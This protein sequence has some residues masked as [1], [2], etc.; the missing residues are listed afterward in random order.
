MN[1]RLIAL[2]LALHAAAALW[3]SFAPLDLPSA[4]A[5]RLPDERW[6]LDDDERTDTDEALSL[7]TAGHLFTAAAGP[8][9]WH[10]AQCPPHCRPGLAARSEN[11][12]QS[13]PVRWPWVSPM[14]VRSERGG[15]DG[16]AQTI[17]PALSSVSA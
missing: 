4:K 9:A 6:Q 3:F 16:Y 10:R 17:A 14:L 12:A 13:R 2:V 7:I 15:E 1:A 8:A 5:L 11:S